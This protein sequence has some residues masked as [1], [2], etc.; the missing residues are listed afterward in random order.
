MLTYD[1]RPAAYNSADAQLLTDEVQ[2]EYAHR[3]GGGGDINPID[4]A[5]FV[6][7]V[8]MFVMAYVDEMPAAMGGW[9]RHGDDAE[10]RRMY[11]RPQ[12]QRQG[13]ARIVLKRIEQTA[14][15]AGFTRMI[16]ETGLE[17][18]EAIT[19]YRSEGYS[20]IPAFGFYAEEP[21]SVHLGKRLT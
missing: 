3:Y 11:V 1:L 16:L 13:L 6:P 10:I 8:G 19:L 21:L 7:P 5:E 14:V 17:Q 9:R 2:L 20:D 15:E 12:F 4:P 18:P